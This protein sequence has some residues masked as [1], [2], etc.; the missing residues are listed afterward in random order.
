MI[1]SSSRPDLNNEYY[2][3]ERMNRGEKIM[4]DLRPELAE[5]LEIRSPADRVTIQTAFVEFCV[6]H[7]IVDLHCHQ[8]NIGRHPK[9]RELLGVECMQ[10][11]DLFKHLRG[12]ILPF[13]VEEREIERRRMLES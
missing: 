8:Y 1:I 11:F 4:Y 3:K 13:S 9:M 2:M 5:L 7:D 10:S 12:L 6:E